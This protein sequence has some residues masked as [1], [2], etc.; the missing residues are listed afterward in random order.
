MREK[1]GSIKLDKKAILKAEAN[2]KELM[3]QLGFYEYEKISLEDNSNNWLVEKI[4]DYL[5]KTKQG[6]LL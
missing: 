4:L 3:T 2:Q 6:N 1:D 5:K